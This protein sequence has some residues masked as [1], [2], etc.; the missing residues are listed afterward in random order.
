MFTRVYRAK[1]QSG[2]CMWDGG[3][4]SRRPGRMSMQRVHCTQRWLSAL[5]VDV[6][7]LELR[8]SRGIHVSR[9]SAQRYL[10]T[11]EP[12]ANA[13]VLT[14]AARVY[15]AVRFQ[16]FQYLCTCAVDCRA[17]RWIT[18]GEQHVGAVVKA[19]PALVCVNQAEC[20]QKRCGT[21]G[22]LCQDSLV[23]RS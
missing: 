16:Q 17:Y 2:M 5:V 8:L 19:C 9:S 22:F 14:R 6:A 12:V 10:R 23:M 13:V 21:T 4:T 18:R 7:S 3:L 11:R 1:L 20:H 15:V